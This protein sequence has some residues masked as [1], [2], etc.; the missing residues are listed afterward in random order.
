MEEKLEVWGI[1]FRLNVVIG[2]RRFSVLGLTCG[3]KEKA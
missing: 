2:R 3:E 1:C